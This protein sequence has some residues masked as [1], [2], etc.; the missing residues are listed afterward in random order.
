LKYLYSPATRYQVDSV[1]DAPDQ[2]VG[3][4]RCASAAGACTV[5]ATIMEA[6]AHPGSTVVISPGRY[7]LTIPPLLGRARTDYTL[8]DAAHG[9]LKVFKATHPV[10]LDDA[11]RQPG[12]R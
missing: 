9:N 4:G 12:G 6:N 10:H 2:T 3:D 11:A 1:A 5:R 7:S 8:A